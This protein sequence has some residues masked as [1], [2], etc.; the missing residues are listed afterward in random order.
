MPLHKVNLTLNPV[1]T[2]FE[3][4]PICP[5]MSGTD[6]PLRNLYVL[7]VGGFVEAAR[8]V[9]GHADHPINAKL[10]H[11]RE[12]FNCEIPCP[13]LGGVPLRP[14]SLTPCACRHSRRALRR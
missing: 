9:G 1:V 14:F 6:R 13:G 5:E 4:C 8:L 3:N 10:S 7:S 11:Y 2:Q 12:C